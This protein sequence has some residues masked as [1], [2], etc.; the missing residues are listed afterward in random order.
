MAMPRV[1][2]S[3]DSVSI[4]ARVKRAIS[5]DG[6]ECALSRVSIRARVKRAI[7]QLRHEGVW[8]RGFNPRPRE[9]GDDRTA[10]NAMAALDVSIRARVK[11]AILAVAT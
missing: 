11:R 4:R 2:S 10:I 7:S 9:A 3:P 1:I 5:P 6:V 8:R